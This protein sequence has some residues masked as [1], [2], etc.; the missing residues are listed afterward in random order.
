MRYLTLISTF[1]L[2]LPMAA[3]GQ[4]CDPEAFKYLDSAEMD[5]T[6][7]LAY[8]RTVTEKNFERRKQDG[9]IGVTIPDTPFTFDGSWSD[10]KEKRRQFFE[11]YEFNY[12]YTDASSYLK[13][14]LDTNSVAAYTQCLKQNFPVRAWLE[15]G[16]P[17]AKKVVIKI[18]VALP[19]VLGPLPV[20]IEFSGIEQGQ[21]ASLNRD[22]TNPGN[23]S[24]SVNRNT[25]EA[26]TATFRIKN[27][28]G[29]DVVSDSLFI[30]KLV[31]RIPDT[32]F[33][34]PLAHCIGSG[35][36]QGLHL[37]GPE[38]DACAGIGGGWGQYKKAAV[39]ATEIC[40]C[41]GKGGVDGIASWAPRGT[42][43]WGVS[44]WGTHDTDCRKLTKGGYCACRGQGGAQGVQL[45]GPNGADCG[46]IGGGWGKYTTSCK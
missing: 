29:Q 27:S 45:W 21:P 17:K 46:G 36:V 20:A 32:R 6:T 24:I 35:G 15:V 16:S 9:S 19:G 13:A 12:S 44:A 34:A 33:S 2:A 28:A 41:R 23:T 43:C 25:S 38:N 5:V 30:P 14:G 22:L 39:T 18:E 4:D 1:V 37:W 40:S 7:S 3:I 10:F 42:P 8:L 11:Q 31:V 26:F